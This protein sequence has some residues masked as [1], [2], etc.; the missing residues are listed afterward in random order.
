MNEAAERCSI[1]SR[2]I[3]TLGAPEHSDTRK[4][5]V[6]LCGDLLR[7]RSSLFTYRSTRL[8]RKRAKWRPRECQSDARRYGKSRLRIIRDPASALTIAPRTRRS[9]KLGSKLSQRASGE[10]NISPGAKH[11]R[12]SRRP[13]NRCPRGEEKSRARTSLAVFLLRK[14]LRPGNSL[15]FPR[16]AQS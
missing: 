7:L 10:I 13:R 5:P 9:W 12:C 3:S 6:A 11:T 4:L 14:T 2:I 15:L 16:G 8:R 1:R